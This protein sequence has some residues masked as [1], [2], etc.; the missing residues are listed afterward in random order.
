MAFLDIYSWEIHIKVVFLNIQNV[1]RSALFYEMH[2]NFVQF[3]I[4]NL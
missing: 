1:M 2:L 3:F 4:L